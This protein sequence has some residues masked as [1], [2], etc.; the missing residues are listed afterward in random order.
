MD[1]TNTLPRPSWFEWAVSI[2]EAVAR[3]ATCPRASVGALIL[4]QQYHVLSVGYNGSPPR[5][6]HCLDVGCLL[7]DAGRHCRRVIHAEQNAIGV[8]A[9][10]GIRLEGAVIYVW[11]SRDREFGS[12]DK[13]H[14]LILASGIVR[15]VDRQ[16]RVVEWLDG[17]LGKPRVV[18]Q[19]TL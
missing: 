9:R 18:K 19:Y 5:E 1:I 14:Q 12:C 8:A 13:C 7:D 17:G 4:D 15:H 3:R 16:G 6:P 10:L 2:A 11:D